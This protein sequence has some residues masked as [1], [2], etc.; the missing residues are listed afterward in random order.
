GFKLVKFIT[1]ESE[2]YS[3]MQFRHIFV[4]GPILALLPAILAQKWCYTTIQDSNGFVFY[5]ET[6]K[7]ASVRLLPPE[8]W[9]GTREIVT[10]KVGIARKAVYWHLSTKIVLRGE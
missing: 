8:G 1:G 5:D 6:A 4:I 2:A 10:A 9:A 3:I 7:I